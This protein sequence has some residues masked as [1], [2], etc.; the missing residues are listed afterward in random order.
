MTVDIPL[1]SPRSP[2]DGE[3]AGPTANPRLSALT[4]VRPK[5]MT[6]ATFTNHIPLPSPATDP[7]NVSEE[8]SEW[9]PTSLFVAPRPHYKK[10]MTTQ[11]PWPNDSQLSLVAERHEQFFDA[12]GRNSLYSVSPCAKKGFDF[13]NSSSWRGS[14]TRTGGSRALSVMRGSRS[15]PTIRS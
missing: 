6:Q 2:G 11:S 1:P 7:T 8:T 14:A 9:R 5:R 3:G 13:G 15:V 10:R 4:I 12:F